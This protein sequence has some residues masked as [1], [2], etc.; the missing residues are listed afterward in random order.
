[1]LVFIVW[2]NKQLELVPNEKGTSMPL[3]FESGVPTCSLIKSE[4][5]TSTSS[6]GHQTFCVLEQRESLISLSWRPPSLPEYVPLLHWTA[7]YRRDFF[8][9]QIFCACTESPR[10]LPSLRH[11][12]VQAASPTLLNKLS[13][14]K[15]QITQVRPGLWSEILAWAGNCVFDKRGQKLFDEKI[16]L[17]TPQLPSVNL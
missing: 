7:D 4:H 5:A 17:A 3:T 10:V 2:P 12:T 15:K 8:S 11:F 9:R 13:W 14:S 6:V 16:V 1:M